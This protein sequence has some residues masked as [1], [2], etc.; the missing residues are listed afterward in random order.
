MRR[1]ATAVLDRALSL[2]CQLSHKSVFHRNVWTNGQMLL[3]A[4]CLTVK[5]LVKVFHFFMFI[6]PMLVSVSLRRI[7]EIREIGVD[8]VAQVQ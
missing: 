8:F 4:C 7:M 2:L 5:S 1:Y 6:D 3:K